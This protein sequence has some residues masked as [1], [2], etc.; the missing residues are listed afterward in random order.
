MYAIHTWYYDCYQ[1]KFD[2]CLNKVTNCIPVIILI[3]YSW[4]NIFLSHRII[5][6]SV[7]VIIYS[8]CMMS[9]TQTNINFIFCPKHI[10]LT[11]YH[12]ITIYHSPDIQS[13]EDVSDLAALNL[14]KAI[15]I[16]NQIENKYK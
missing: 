4:D 14:I 9:H 15:H 5:L 1:P 11:I 3:T 7:I 6:I 10:E 2:F 8:G 12:Q 13:E 16:K